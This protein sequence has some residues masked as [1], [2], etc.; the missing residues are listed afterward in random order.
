MTRTRNPTIDT[1]K[2]RRGRVTCR[3]EIFSFEARGRAKK[4]GEEEGKKKRIPCLDRF[5]V[6]LFWSSA[7][8]LLRAPVH[9]QRR[10]LFNV[11][12][13]HRAFPLKHRR[14][15][16]YR[17]IG[18]LANYILIL[19]TRARII[20]KLYQKN[21]EVARSEFCYRCPNVVITLQTLK[22]SHQRV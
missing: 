6:N 14:V 20:S 10:P 15:P 16:N 22:C 18:C 4:E 1:W 2:G 19:Y 8:N 9:G 3:R 17:Y 11:S 21:R 5:C 7:C 12:M 13:D